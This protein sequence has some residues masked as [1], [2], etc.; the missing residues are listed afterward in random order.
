[1]HGRRAGGERVH[2]DPG[3]RKSMKKKKLPR[4][5]RAGVPNAA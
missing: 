3:S 5:G 1:M 2:P 4:V